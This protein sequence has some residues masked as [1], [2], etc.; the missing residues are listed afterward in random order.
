VV[1]ERVKSANDIRLLPTPKDH[2][3][4]SIDVQ[5]NRKAAVAEVVSVMRRRLPIMIMLSI[6]NM[7]MI[8]YRV[9]CRREIE[10]MLLLLSMT[11]IMQHYTTLPVCTLF[12]YFL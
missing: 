2:F 7:T 4:L 6:V 3:R 10:S 11:E 9:D 1:G 8:I 12:L 5:K